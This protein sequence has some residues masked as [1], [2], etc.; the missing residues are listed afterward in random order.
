M[1]N[2]NNP[3][4]FNN[5]DLSWIDFDDRVLRQAKVKQNPL[6]E[7]LRFLGITQSNIDE[8]F[9][10]RVAKILNAIKAGDGPDDSGQ[11]PTQV[12]SKVIKKAHW[13]VRRQYHTLHDDLMP[14][15]DQ[16]NI[17]LINY[18]DLTKHQREFIDRYF[19]QN[20]YP[21]ITPMTV[22]F[23]R[24][25]P[26]VRDKQLNVVA[27][28][29]DK[30]GR[31][32]YAIVPIS[33]AF[34]RVVKLPDAENDF[35]LQEEIIKH[36]IHDLFRGVKISKTSS[37]RICRAMDLEVND[38]HTT[39][40]RSEVQR[41][42]QQLQYGKPVRLEVEASMS[43]RLKKWL[44]PHVKLDLHD[45]YELDGPVDLNFVNGIIKQVKGHHDLLY[46]PFTPYYP[47]IIKN[48]NLF[49]VISNHD[50]FLHHPY[51]SFTPVIDLIRQASSDRK[52][53][54]IKMSLYRV[55]S[56][57]P[58]I[59]ALEK[60]ASNGKQVTVL[61]ELK[62]RGD[63][64]H[65]IHW[66]RELEKAGCN[67]IYTLAGLKTHCKLTLVVRKEK[68]GIKRYMHM[69]TGN[70]NDKTARLY[71]DMGI[72]TAN[73]EMGNDAT[74]IFN[75]I[76][77]L[78]TSSSLH[79]KKLVISPDGIRNYLMKM[80]DNEINNAKKGKKALIQMKM[81]SLSD[82]PM[83]KK[84]YEASSKGVKIN[85]IVRGL[86]NLRV[87]I[88]KVSDNIVVHSIVGRLLEH[89]RIY[90]FHNGGH[91]RVFISSADLM[92]RNLSRR[93]ELLIP[94]EQHN[95]KKRILHIYDLFWHDNVKT[96]VLQ[97]D[98]HWKLLKPGDE[99]PLDV[100]QYLIDHRVSISDSL[101]KPT[102][103][104]SFKKQLKKLLKRG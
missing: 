51:D 88:P 101:F 36:H 17:H 97:P 8:F 104:F 31:Q 68:N 77:G 9:N 67:V 30:E 56:H 5:R 69:A 58:I 19:E 33:N 52:V 7:R 35:I 41:D 20:L 27:D 39:D 83:I 78:S 91:P 21:T 6:L 61:I 57:S 16:H 46:K 25:F 13:F 92:K 59:T 99:K 42:L 81:N 93:V 85:L 72:F 37:F 2:F 12:L 60:A 73:E 14:A 11:T 34:S 54:A 98:D 15:L 90:C 70:Y 87:G 86:C 55:S 65:N 66:S 29:E 89:S 48:H 79:L 53:I 76:S 102:P 49:K 32:F 63:E 38:L 80:I 45:I 62:A 82:G 94:I 18:E 47:K 95:I 43:D 71:T 96:S 103:H 64:Q 84:L 1:D 28:I 26:F 24:P 10:V 40:F 75:M 23:S 22:N 50:I 4:Y 100:Q 3:K 44:T 74:K